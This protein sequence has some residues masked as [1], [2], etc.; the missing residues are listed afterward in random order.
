[1]ATTDVTGAAPTPSQKSW[2]ARFLDAK[3]RGSTQRI[4]FIAGL[5]TF[6]TMAY[7]IFVNTD[8]MSAAGLNRTALVI[9][10]IFAAAV[11]TLVMGLWADLPWA[12]APGLGYNALFA[13]TV[14]LQNHVPVNAALALVFLDGL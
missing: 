5:T 6:V 4:E 12:L 14:V 13:F 1:M 3:A 2:L 11:P 7:I 9:G 10:T 8:I